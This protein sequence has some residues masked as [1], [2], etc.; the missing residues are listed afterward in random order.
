MEGLQRTSRITKENG[1]H[2]ANPAQLFRDIKC[3]SLSNYGWAECKS[4]FFHHCR[5]GS[6]HKF[7][8]PDFV[9]SDIVQHGQ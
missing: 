8:N 4:D 9:G 6:V 5:F 7:G 1:P 3:C 2:P